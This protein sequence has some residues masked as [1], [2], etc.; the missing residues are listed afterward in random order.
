MSRSERIALIALFCL[1]YLV[2]R[3]LNGVGHELESIAI[4]M[5]KRVTTL[6]DRVTDVEIE[7]VKRGDILP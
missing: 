5:E 2:T 6:E 7:C 3:F 1:L 4:T